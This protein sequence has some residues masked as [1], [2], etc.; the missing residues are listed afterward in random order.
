MRSVAVSVLGIALG[1]WPVNVGA[2]PFAYIKCGFRPIV[3]AD[4][5]PA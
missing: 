5:G 4:F 2:A 3:N 1:V